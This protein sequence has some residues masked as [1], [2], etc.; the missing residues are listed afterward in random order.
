MKISAFYALL[1]VG[2]ILATGIVWW[3]MHRHLSATSSA[4][5]TSTTQG[6]AGTPSLAGLSIY[7]NGQYGFSIFYPEQ[8]KTES[9]FDTQYFLPATWRVNAFSQATGSPIIAII[10]Y[11][12]KSDDSYPRYFE[13][14]VRVG[15]SADPRELAAC[16][17]PSGDET[18]LPDKVINGTTWKAF[19]VQDAG[20][21]QYLNGIS[22]RTIHDNTC[23]ALEQ[24]ETGSS[25]L[26]DKPSSADISQ[27]TLDQHYKDL[28]SIIASFSFARS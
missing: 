20:M 23:F 28:S 14:E 17:S 7:T 26:D 12:T 8:D 5:A 15:A 2:I 6:E 4:T 27:S 21:M 1:A 19:T 10:G 22:Y 25:Y 24:V 16:D 9:V 13:T 18:A 11:Q 3:G